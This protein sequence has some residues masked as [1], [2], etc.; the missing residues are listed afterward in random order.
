MKWWDT[1]RS[2]IVTS[3]YTNTSHQVYLYNITNTAPRP[4]ASC[5]LSTPLTR[6]RKLGSQ[7]DAVKGYV[8]D[9]ETAFGA[10]PAL[11]ESARGDLYAELATGAESGIDYSV[12]WCKRTD[13]EN[14]TDNFPFLRTLNG[15]SIIP[16]DLNA[17]LSGDHGLVSTSSSCT[18]SKRLYMGVHPGD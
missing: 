10:Q 12:R 9:Y 3:P 16:V 18:A 15:K 17:L 14:K 13:F 2:T 1:N 8:E 7:A 11:N 5:P 6:L 4:E